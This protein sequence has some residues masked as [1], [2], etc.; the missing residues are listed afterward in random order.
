MR[1]IEYEPHK[2]IN[3]QRSQLLI[4]YYLLKLCLLVNTQ[5]KPSPFQERAGLRRV[6][7]HITTNVNRGIQTLNR[8]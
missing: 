4:Y 6:G 8:C 5:P 7:K 1:I 3:D 2:K